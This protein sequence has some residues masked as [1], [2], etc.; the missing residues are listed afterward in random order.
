MN[1][2]NIK[3]NGKYY[4]TNISSRED[5]IYEDDGFFSDVPASGS[6]SR[7][8]LALNKYVK[9]NMLYDESDDYEDDS[10]YFSKE[11][12]P[13]ESRNKYDSDSLRSN[14]SAEEKAA[15]QTSTAKITY[16]VTSVTQLTDDY[17][18]MQLQDKS[19]GSDIILDNVNTQNNAIHEEESDPESNYTSNKPVYA[20]ENSSVSLTNL[21]N[22]DNNS[23]VPINANIRDQVVHRN[24][25]T[26]LKKEEYRHTLHEFSE[27]GNRTNIYPDVYA[28]LPYK[29]PRRYVESDV[30][31][32]YRCPVRHDPLPLVPEREL[33]RQQAEHMKRLYREQKRNKYLQ[34]NAILP[35]DIEAFDAS[36]KVTFESN[37]VFELICLTFETYTCC[38]TNFGLTHLKNHCPLHFTVTESVTDM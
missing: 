23:S 22:I 19:H 12:S 20:S 27:W 17:K 10:V 3:D 18:S 37:N 21:S 35:A 15:R 16:G 9:K 14:E 25:P 28:P 1:R 4:K 5:I 11:T 34:E 32:H 38:I 7:S 13:T 6:L 2:N 36:M 24:K 29:S 33:A 8:L 30:N 26:N 31:I